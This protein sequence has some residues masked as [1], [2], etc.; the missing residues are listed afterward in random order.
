[1]STVN[2]LIPKGGK[3][4]NKKTQKKQKTRQSIGACKIFLFAA[5]I[6][7]SP[8]SSASVSQKRFI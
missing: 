7:S 5:I 1:L 3:I 8:F 2:K 4:K 6:S